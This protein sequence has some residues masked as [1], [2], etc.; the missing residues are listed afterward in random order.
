M[1]ALNIMGIPRFNIMYADK[2]DNI[3]YVSNAQLPVRDTSYDWE[4]LLQGNTSKTCIGEYHKLAD[5]PQL[6]NPSQGYLFNTNNSPFNCAHSLDN[7]IEEDYT[8]TFSFREKINNR[9]LRFEELIKGYDQISYQDFMDIKYDQQYP[10]PI[11]CP[12]EINDVFKYNSVDHPEI[13]DLIDIIQSWDRKADTNSIGAAQ[14]YMY[15]DFLNKRISQVK[16]DFD[17]PV[18]SDLVINSLKNTRD[19]FL[20]KFGRIDVPLKDFQKHLRGDVELP[21][22]GLVDMIAATSTVSYKDGMVKAVSG[23]SYIM[24]VRYGEDKVDIETVLPY[25]ISAHPDSPNFTDQM[26]LYVNHQ[27]KKMSLDKEIILKGATKIYH[28]K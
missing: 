16:H 13:K 27:R 10:T 12:F 28:P 8:E 4:G 6:L 19:Y 1:E 11:F 17:S 2:E 23:D 7:P 3:Y 9:S 26:H 14:W 15:Y 20:D 5:L 24:L 18:P 21:V 22:S 25:G